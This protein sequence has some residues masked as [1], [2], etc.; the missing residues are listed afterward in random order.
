MLTVYIEGKA[1]WVAHKQ[2]PADT[3][4]LGKYLLAMFPG[5]QWVELH[6]VTGQIAV[7]GQTDPTWLTYAVVAR[8]AEECA[9]WRPIRI[10]LRKTD[11]TGHVL[12]KH[13]ATTLAELQEGIQQLTSVAVVD[14][15]LLHKGYH[16]TDS[17]ATIEQIGLRQSSILHLINLR[18]Q[19]EN[20]EQVFLLNVQTAQSF[21]QTYQIEVAEGYSVLQLKERVGEVFEIP[22]ENL[23]ITYCG[24]ILAH[25]EISLRDY[26]LVP[27]AYINAINEKKT[28][29]PRSDAKHVEIQLRET[30]RVVPTAAQHET[31]VAWGLSSSQSVVKSEVPV[32]SV[33]APV[34]TPIVT[35]EDVFAVTPVAPVNVPTVTG[36]K[37]NEKKAVTMSFS[38]SSSTGKSS[39]SNTTREGGDWTATTITNRQ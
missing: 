11:K 13:P 34:E 5:N 39:R 23:L 30:T 16:L 12:F 9:K 25:D 28:F 22:I 17:N 2:L 8:N 35:P 10:T 6:D 14:Q 26:K 18:E 20:S 37:E 3:A 29:K 33:V 19:P 7:G 4:E 21:S 1:T 32:V 38:I 27:G 15:E 24:M 31:N 36:D